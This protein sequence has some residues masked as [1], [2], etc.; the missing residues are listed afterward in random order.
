MKKVLIAIPTAKY[1]EPETFKAIYDLIIPPGYTADFQFFYG[2]RIDQIRNL[3]A[4]ST[5]RY[6]YDYLFAIDS[7][8][9]P[10]QDTLAK[11]LSHQVDVVSG[12]YMSSHLP[13]SPEIF[14]WTGNGGMTQCHIRELTS[15][16][17]LVPIAGCGFGCVLVD[18][19][20]FRRVPH[21]R[22]EYHVALDHNDTVSE[23]TDFALKC[24]RAGVKIY[25]DP[26]V[27]CGHKKTTYVNV[28][29]NTEQQV[30]PALQ[31]LR[32]LREGRLLPRTH[33]NY[34]KKL[35]GEGVNPRVIYDIGACA[36]HWFDEAKKIWPGAEIIAFEGMGES[37]ELFKEAKIPHHIAV[38]GDE[39]KTVNYWVNP[40]HPGGNSRFIENDRINTEARKY[41]N[42]THKRSVDM[43]T[44]DSLIQKHSLPIPNL[45]KIDVQGGELDVLRGASMI[46]GHTEHI[47]LELQS[48]EYNTGAPLADEVIAW[49]NERGYDLR[50]PKFSVG[51]L[52]PVPTPNGTKYV[53]VDADYHFVLRKR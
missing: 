11:L 32:E 45:V 20:V 48:V 30:S 17:T 1:I 29:K 46:V 53:H 9:I 40:H 49:M 34:L 4:H 25:C 10:P 35:E 7:D 41:F 44:L 5:L 14:K 47:I 36:L 31:R 16:K 51:A 38:L 28:P 21:P 19:E 37:V 52:H 22:F 26:T 43:V 12:V 39:C 33:V 18:A 24:H 42:D 13:E 3:I 50:T 23:D 27:H 15:Q 8:V 2:Y 6:G